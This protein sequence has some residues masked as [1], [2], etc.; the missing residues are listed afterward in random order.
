L[1]ADWGFLP[2]IDKRNFIA[3][4]NKRI[5]RKKMYGSEDAW[6]TEEDKKNGSS[7]F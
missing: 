2:F 6:M 4:N 3:Y 1:P 7:P 5:D